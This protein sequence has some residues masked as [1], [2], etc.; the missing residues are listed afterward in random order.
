MGCGRGAVGTEGVVRTLTFDKAVG[1]QIDGACL[2]QGLVLM[3]DLDRLAGAAGVIAQ[4]HPFADQGGIDFIDDA[5]EADGAIG[6]DLTHGLEQKQRVKIGG[7]A[8]KGDLLGG[9]RP[10]IKRRLSAQALVRVVVVF[11]LDPGPKPTVERLEAT[12]IVGAE[13]AEQLGADGFEPALDFA[14][15][16]SRQ[17]PPYRRLRSKSSKSPIP[18]TRSQVSALN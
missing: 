10:A 12:G 2:L 3:P 1:V 5:V 18:F 7:G 13:A 15:P 16:K 11:A 4:R 6:I 9:R 17:L 14:L 8:D